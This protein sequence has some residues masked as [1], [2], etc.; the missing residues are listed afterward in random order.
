MLVLVNLVHQVKL[1]DTNKNEIEKN[2]DWKYIITLH[3][4]S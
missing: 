3:N 2:N 4:I 1:N